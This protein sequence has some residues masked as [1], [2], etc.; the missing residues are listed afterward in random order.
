MHKTYFSIYAEDFKQM[1]VDLSDNEIV[2]LLSALLDFCYWGESDFQPQNKKQQ[3]YFEKLKAKYDKDLLLYE[4]RSN[5]GKNGMK[6]RWN[7]KTDNK[8]DNLLSKTDN[9]RDNHL[10]TLTGNIYNI[11]IS[12]SEDKSS[13]EDMGVK[14]QSHFDLP[15]LNAVL[16]KHGLPQIAKLNDDRKAKLKQ[17]VAEAGSF[18]N[19]VEEVD[20]ALASS[21]FLRGDNNRG[22]RADFD[23]FL[24][25]SKWQKVVEGCYR[26]RDCKKTDDEFYRKLEEL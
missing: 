9:K 12:S 19:F 8:T 5:A 21:S 16:A 25:K 6:K 20:R 23:F 7:N 3:F 15:S 13:S 10:N 22:W 4:T 14:T 26:D 2:L 24:Q 17:R 1:K 18:Q 11:P